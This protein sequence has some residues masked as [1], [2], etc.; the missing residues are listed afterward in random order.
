MVNIISNINEPIKL[1]AG[2]IVWLKLND[3]ETNFRYISLNAY[4]ISVLQNGK[5]IANST[6]FATVEI[7]NGNEKIAEIFC[8]VLPGKSALPVL[9]NRYNKIS[10]PAD[11]LVLLN[12]AYVSKKRQIYIAKKVRKSYYKMC[13]EAKAENVCIYAS[14]GYRRFSD[15]LAL[16]DQFTQSEGTEAAMKRCAPAGFSEHHTGL[17]LDLGGGLI[18]DG[19]Y[20]SNSQVVY[21]WIAENCYKYGFMIKNPPNKEH[22]TGTMYEPWHIRYIADESLAKVLHEESITLDEYFD[23]YIS[24]AYE[25]DLNNLSV[26][27]DNQ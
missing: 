17:A 26:F 9:F 25:I 20:V 23:N 19:A 18:V 13:R 22:I 15:Q 10:Y 27:L 2:E 6:G 4:V 1:N 12:K 14:Q 7:Y 3:S 11:E 8:E 21:D 5:I 16:I 24:V